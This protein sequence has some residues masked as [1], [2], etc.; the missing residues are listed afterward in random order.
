M[1]FML[2]DMTAY[3]SVSMFEITSKHQVVNQV[4]LYE[5]FGISPIPTILTFLSTCSAAAR[6]AM[7]S[8]VLHRAFHRG[9]HV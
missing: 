7:L 9:M 4:H 6:L 8:T 3:L 1:S 2:F 5:Y